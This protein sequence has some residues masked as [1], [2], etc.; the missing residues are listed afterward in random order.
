MSVNV[1]R[2]ANS[3]DTTPSSINTRPSVSRSEANP[4]LTHAMIPGGASCV[5]NSGVVNVGRDDIMLVNA[6][7]TQWQPR[8][9]VARS[10]DRVH[11]TIEH[12]TPHR[13]PMEYPYQQHEGIFDT[14]ITPF[15]DHFF[16]THN[17]ASHL[18]GRIW[19]SQTQDFNSFKD[20][21]FITAPDHR[22]CVIFPEKIEGDYVRLERPNVEASGDIYLSRSPDLIHWGRTQLV[23]ERNRRYWESAKIGPGAP[24]I[25]T[26]AGWL[27]IYHGARK[28]MNG[29]SYQAGAMLLDLKD[30]S[31]IVGKM[32]HCLLEPDADYERNG[33]TPN[34]VFPTAAV[35]RDDGSLSIYYGAADTCMAHASVN[36]EELIAAC[37]NGEA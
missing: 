28:S 11:F 2:N 29:Y 10:S 34:V 27:C 19:L 6:W 31:R 25:R 13:P 36:L 8:F 30:P 26:L 9:M 22:N 1:S 24:P 15:A 32:N 33:I 23:L 37:L 4:I 20:L 16:I 14:R 35:P 7:D 3:L 21:G 5:F 18:G 12:Q 17:V